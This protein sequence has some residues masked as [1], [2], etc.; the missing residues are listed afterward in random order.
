MSATGTTQTPTPVTPPKP[1]PPLLWPVKGA[2]YP[3]A[4][5]IL[6]FHRIIAYYGNFYAKG[7]GVL[8]EYP[9]VEMLRRFNI[10]IKKWNDA[11]PQTPVIPAVDYI[12]VTAQGSAGR[13]GKYRA[14]MPGDQIEKAITLA[15][16]IHGIVILEIQVGLSTV[17]IETPLLEK[18]LKNPI[19]HLAIDPEFSMKTG[20]KPGTVVGTVDATDI[21][22]AANYL[23][24]LVR[25]NNLPPKVLIVHR[26]TQK[27]VT[28]YKN[29]TTLPEIQ[30][31]MD[32]D[33][34]GSPE[35][36]LGTY[37]AFEYLQPVQ[38]TGFKLFYKND[39]FA[40]SKRMLT[41]ADLLK[42]RPAPV[43]IQF[44]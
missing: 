23:A 18:Y 24:K 4:G 10:E 6:P 28:N 39:L 35:R 25:D 19:V 15:N 5:A 1:E 22:W 8:G 11:D 29:I 32:M 20:A 7:M 3:N 40:P 42:L 34:W 26:Y 33:G 41:P 12:A 31:I 30:L 27:M 17:Q 9:E 36:K 14:R 43:F 38:F 16:K 13:D 2:A 21:N 44:Q 37:Q